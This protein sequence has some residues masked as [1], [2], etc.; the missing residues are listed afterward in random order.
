LNFRLCVAR[1]TIEHMDAQSCFC[2]F[3]NPLRSILLIMAATLL[4]A[5]NSGAESAEH[6]AEKLSRDHSRFRRQPRQGRTRMASPARCLRRA[7]DAPDLHPVIYTPRSL[8]GVSGGIK[9]LAA[10]PERGSETIALREAMKTFLIAGATCSTPTRR[11]Y[12]WSAAMARTRR[13]A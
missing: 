2:A 3:M 5:C 9:L 11:R 10:P 12:R 4:A 8:L 1:R 6:N 13:S 7:T